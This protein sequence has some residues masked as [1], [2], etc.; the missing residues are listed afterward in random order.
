VRL[1]D[2]VNQVRR[3]ISELTTFV[4][5]PD[6]V[7]LQRGR[8]KLQDA[9][10]KAE[11]PGAKQRSSS[12]TLQ[13]SDEVRVSSPQ[14]Q[15]QQNSHKFRAV[16]PPIGRSTWSSLL[17]D[18]TEIK[19]LESGKEIGGGRGGRY[20][21]VALLEENEVEKSRVYQAVQVLKD[22][23]VLLKEYLL[24]KED[25]SDHDAEEYLNK[26]EYL[27]NLSITEEQ[28]KK[29]RV[30]IPHDIIVD[31][32]AQRCYL[33]TDPV[34]NSQSLRDYIY[35]GGA[36]S[37]VKTVKI[38][39]DILQTLWFLHNH[40]FRFGDS[41]QSGLAHGNLSPDSI[42]I[43]LNREQEP[44]SQTPFSVYLADLALWEHLFVRPPTSQ[45]QF[46][47]DQIQQDFRDLGYLCLYLLSGGKVD[48]DFGRAVDLL[49]IEDKLAFVAPSA[50]D[51]FMRRLLGLE[52]PFSS[53]EE[54]RKT[55]R[56]VEKK[57]AGELNSISSDIERKNQKKSQIISTFLKV[58]LLAVSAGLAGTL[59]RFL[60]ERFYDPSDQPLIIL[61]NDRYGCCLSKV[62]PMGGEQEAKYAAVRSGHWH[63]ILVERT[64]IFSVDSRN[65]QD[66]PRGKTLKDE[67]EERHPE[68]LKQ[69]EYQCDLQLEWWQEQEDLC[70]RTS[71]EIVQD[72][73]ATKIDFALLRKRKNLPSKLEQQVVAYDVVVPVV[74]FSAYTRSQGVTQFLEGKIALEQLRDLYTGKSRTINGK[75]VQKVYFSP[76]SYEVEVRQ[77]FEEFLRKG[78]SPEVAE[79]EVLGFRENYSKLIQ[80]NKSLNI[81]VLL[82]QILRDFEN[83]K[84]VS[85]GLTFLSSVFAQCSVYPLAIVDGGQVFQA[86]VQNNGK[87]LTPE[88]DLCN[89][90]GSYF[91]I[92]TSS[93]ESGE[94]PFVYPLAVVYPKEGNGTDAGRRFAEMLQT[95]EG[96]YL[97][98]E[99]GLI[100]MRKLRQY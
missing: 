77:L 30:L 19:P 35:K 25:F 66:Y 40:K 31:R 46:L 75:E 26:F 95:D 4:R 47:D 11:F 64:G 93:L 68:L 42:Q 18:S 54:A 50:L 28:G 33:V 56:K 89:D 36:I 69:Y 99:M 17:E 92:F 20:Q 96:Q 87:P 38:V 60:W 58:L 39:D 41:F 14:R 84:I 81:N 98:R 82:E 29:F 78:L 71:E 49:S 27:A 32:P 94:F 5:H 85:M 2:V 37:F 62:S 90:K 16:S 48:G 23:T 83:E 63:D 55:L 6:R 79:K 76:I 72:L 51:S 88:V 57:P 53:A 59:V 8:R 43:V 9:Y 74:A 15:G 7:L 86:I 13:E 1:T 45:N 80:Q 24:L 3:R 44:I 34:E 73:E 22:K 97:L 12:Q 67:I 10:E 70:D 65:S 21:I 100:P 61:E 52:E 91:P